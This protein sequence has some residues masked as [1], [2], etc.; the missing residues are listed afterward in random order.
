[1]EFSR[2]FG[3]RWGP[4]SL[5]EP[6]PMHV[7]PDDS[8]LYSACQSMSSDVA[9]AL[10]RLKGGRIADD[11]IS[12]IEDWFEPSS[13]SKTVGL[14]EELDERIEIYRNRGEE[15]LLCSTLKARAL[16]AASANEAPDQDEYV[17]SFKVVP[18]ANL[19]GDWKSDCETDCVIVDGDLSVEGT[20]S[21]NELSETLCMIVLGSVSVRNLDCG[22]WV[23]VRDELE[24]EH[25]HACSLNDGILAV[26]GNLTAQTFLET[27][28]Y[29][30]VWG[31]LR[32]S[33]LSTVQNDI[34]VE[35]RVYCPGFNRRSDPDYL[36]GWV[37]S[38]LLEEI[39]VDC[40]NGGIPWNV[41]PSE[42]YRRR[43]LAGESPMSGNLQG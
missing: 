11:A 15:A 24:C 36:S 8:S 23:F 34:V 30:Q 43:I 14:L 40:S 22:G 12:V 35:G 1:M 9:K 13:S 26:G 4:P 10:L 33:F 19:V 5:S 27:G 3:Q 42:A 38:G 16:I 20:L 21:L 7:F 25:L 29:T 28:T 41:Y 31:D 37:H 32:A 17:P 6:P 18:R 2:G 39:E